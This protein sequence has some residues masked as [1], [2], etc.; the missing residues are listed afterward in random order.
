MNLLERHRNIIDFA[1]S[2]LGRRW[3]KNL[4]LTLVY[5]FTVFTLAS[6][7]FFTE[8]V[9]REARA[10]LQGAPEIVVQRLMAGRH[11]M[12]PEG[13]I[14][15]LQNITGVGKVKGRLWGYYFEPSTGAN[16]TIVA[17]GDPPLGAGTIAVGQ[18][19]SRTLHAAEGDLIPL[20]GADGAYMSF[21]VARV[22]SHASELVSADLIEMPAGDLRVL[23]GIPEGVYTD[24]TLKV[25]NERELVVVADKIRRLLPDTRPILRDEILRTYDSLFDWRSGLL[26]VIFAG[27]VAA[28]I[29]FAWDKATSLSMEERREIGVLKAVGWETSEV[30]AMKA[31]EG[32]AISLTA[33]FGGTLL[34]YVHV[35]FSSVLLFEPVLKGWAVLYPRFQLVP[36]IDPYQML[37]LF[38]LTVVPYTVAT[39][40]PSWNAAT[41]DPDSIMRL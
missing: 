7:I 21:E 10:V 29:T 23:F 38:F 27:A 5:A 37:S 28:F 39:V 40:I 12:I 8:A 22:F 36:H 24:L 30:I 16:Y 13:Y 15:T 35:F 20:K 6:V 41:V 2:S 25:R 32:I 14:G 26:L 3:K 34:A 18:G 33:F 11:E 9:K 19:V 17:S 31:W 1:L 4:A